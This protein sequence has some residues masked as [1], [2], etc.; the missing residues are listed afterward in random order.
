[1]LN[2]SDGFAPTIYLL[3]LGWPKTQVHPG[4]L[5]IRNL[6]CLIYT[7]EVEE[8]MKGNFPDA[9]N[10]K[11][12]VAFVNSRGQKL[13]V[14]T[15]PKRAASFSI[16]ENKDRVDY[17]QNKT[18]DGSNPLFQVLCIRTYLHIC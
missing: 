16:A 11:L 6:D 1:M 12:G 5:K 3:S 14:V 15:V 4:P 2:L 8:A 7:E 9:S 18:K 13:T 17:L 10:L